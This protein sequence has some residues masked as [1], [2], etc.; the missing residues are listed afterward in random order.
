MRLIISFFFSFIIAASSKAQATYPQNNGESVRYD[1]IIEMSKAYLS[2]I[3]IMLRDGD[4]TV[5]ASIVN[6]FGLSLMD[7]TYHE[8]KDKVTFH[9]LMGKLNK[10][11]IKRILK[12]DLRAILKLM[13]EGKEKTYFGSR[14][15]K[16][17]FELQ[18]TANQP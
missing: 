6:E 10:W 16:Y 13:Q 8:V 12:K 1:L 11:Y 5:N 17:S 9:T 4:N 14:N 2:G 7:F 18:T 15:I 3:L